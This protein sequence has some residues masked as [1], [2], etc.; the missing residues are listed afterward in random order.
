MPRKPNEFADQ[1]LE[2]KDAGKRNRVNI[3]HVIGKLDEVAVGSEE[4]V[5]L[6]SRRYRATVVD[7]LDWAPPQRKKKTAPKEKRSEKVCHRVFVI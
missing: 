2:S 4:V 6:N 7:L 1:W 3:R 5:K